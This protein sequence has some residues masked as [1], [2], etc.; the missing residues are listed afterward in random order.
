MP[1]SPAIRVAAVTYVALG[2]GFGVG[3]LAALASL[4]R[5]GELP[6]TPRGFRALNGPFERLDP[7]QPAWQ[8]ARPRAGSRQRGRPHLP[9]CGMTHGPRCVS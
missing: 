4:A 2:L 3:A 8:T 9:K 5:N 7:Q 6:M 1:P